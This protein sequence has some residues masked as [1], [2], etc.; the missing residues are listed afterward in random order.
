MTTQMASIAYRQLVSEIIGYYQ[1]ARKALV[2][3]YWQIGRRIVEVEQKGEIKAAYGAK[4]LSKLSADLTRQLGNGFSVSQLTDIRRFYLAYRI[5]RPAVKLGWTQQVELLRVDDLK[6]R[7]ALERKAVREDLNRDELR[8]LVRRETVRAQAA[9]NLASGTQDTGK[10]EQLMPQRGVLYTYRILDPRTVQPKEPGLLLMDLGFSCYRDLDSVT[11]RIFKPYDV[12]ESVKTGDDRYQLQKTEKKESSLFT[13]CGIVEKIV[14]GDTLRVVV[15]LGF[16]TRTR[17]Y[18]RL[19]GIDSPEI[20]TEEGKTTAA[21]VRSRIKVSDSI[22]LTT[23]KSDKYDR[24]LADVYFSNHDGEE[25]FLNN[26][27]LENGLARRV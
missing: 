26:L 11:S 13:F 25:I 16:N 15:D 2:D 27:L 9:G 10:A 1:H 8:A 6:T 18:L 4:L 24:Y 14:D 22:V 20:D 23:S 12:V 3:A 17:Q 19:R 5:S 21:F 7:K